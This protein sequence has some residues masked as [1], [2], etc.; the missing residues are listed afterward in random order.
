[1]TLD[2]ARRYCLSLPD[3]TE[4]PHFDMSSFRVRRKIFATATP[5]GDRLHVFVDEGETAAAVADDPTAFE[6]LWRG[7]QQRGVRVNLA[8]ADAGRVF[9]LLEDSWRRK[10]PKRLVDARDAG[11]AGGQP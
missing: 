4:E 8:A 6:E 1:V 5:D 10:A 2:E 9:E 3:A 7:K 11:R